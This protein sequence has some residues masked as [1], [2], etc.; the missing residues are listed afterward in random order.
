MIRYEYEGRLYDS[1]ENIDEFLEYSGLTKESLVYRKSIVNAIVDP[2]NESIFREV[3]GKYLVYGRAP[4]MPIL[5]FRRGKRS[6]EFLLPVGWCRLSS[7]D[8]VK[9]DKPTRNDIDVNFVAMF[10]MSGNLLESYQAAY[11]TKRS[12]MALFKFLDVID[13]L[14]LR[15]RILAFM[16]KNGFENIFD[17]YGITDDFLMNSLKE[18][19]ESGKG[20]VGD[21][22][23]VMEA[24]KTV[25]PPE[26]KT[27]LD[28]SLLPSVPEPYQIE[29]RI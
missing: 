20:T 4:I 2:Y 12:D 10:L 11:G 14:G 6:F 24:K 15:E 17:K 13:D 16:K 23:K 5:S 18:K 28:G 22:L 8:F 21:I 29:G 27:D 26:K 3:L 19:I 1:Y 25:D 7:Y 9:I